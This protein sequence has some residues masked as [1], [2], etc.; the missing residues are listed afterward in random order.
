MGTLVVVVVV[1]HWDG[2][3]SC[4]LAHHLA[5]AQAE[6]LAACLERSCGKASSIWQPK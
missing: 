3:R 4:F 1:G 6:R 5:Y 2:M